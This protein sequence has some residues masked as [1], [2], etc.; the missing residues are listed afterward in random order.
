MNSVVS[1][2]D[3]MNQTTQG[4]STYKGITGK[5]CQLFVF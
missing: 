1:E 5:Y 3:K 4:I 2:T